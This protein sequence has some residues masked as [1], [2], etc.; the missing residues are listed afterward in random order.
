MQNPFEWC[1]KLGVEVRVEDSRIT[2]SLASF[3]EDMQG[4]AWIRTPRP[5]DFSVPGAYFRLLAHE[6]IHW[7][8]H[9][10]GKLP[11]I[12]A[13]PG[14]SPAVAHEE[15][16][17]E[18]GSMRLAT[19]FGY[20]PLVHDPAMNQLDPRQ[21]VA[22]FGRVHPEGPAGMARALRDAESARNWLH[23]RAGS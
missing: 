12:V 18:L 23:Q 5:E 6:L 10:L 19:D 11:H 17:A 4:R 15:M 1:S 8:R 22:Q 9:R 21:Y 16:V 13:Q 20:S 3:Q 7:A 14:I 2:G